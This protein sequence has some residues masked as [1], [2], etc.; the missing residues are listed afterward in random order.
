[1][2]LSGA[3]RDVSVSLA[4]PTYVLLIIVSVLVQFVIRRRRTQKVQQEAKRIGLSF[5]RESS[6]FLNSNTSGLE[7]LGH[8]SA[9]VARN[10]VF[11][12]IGSKTIYIFDELLCASADSLPSSTTIAA[13]RFPSQT[14]AQNDQTETPTVSEPICT[15]TSPRSA[16]RAL[17][18][19]KRFVAAMSQ[20]STAHS[21]CNYQVDNNSEWLLIYRPGTQVVPREL[22]AFIQ[23]ISALAAEI[24][25]SPRSSA[26]AAGG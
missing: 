13:F 1:M 26:R 9:T 6:P 5:A 12:K 23:R 11:G 22:P 15:K 24:L 14:G 17:A 18:S 25:N 7:V 19:F 2:I 10:V 4:V 8:G 16:E 20:C 3:V 21:I